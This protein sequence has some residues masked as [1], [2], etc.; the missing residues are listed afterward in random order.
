MPVSG[1]INTTM[2]TKEEILAV[3]Q[4]KRV[5][6]DAGS[7]FVIVD[8]KLNVL[9]VNHDKVT[10]DIKQQPGDLLKCNNA[11]HAHEGCGTHENCDYCKLRNMVEQSIREHKKM[12]T[13]AQLLIEGNKEYDVHAVSTP[14]TLHGEE[15]SIV[16]LRD[17]TD[18]TREVM[19]ERIFFHDLLNL[20]GALNGI[21][22]CIEEGNYEETIQVVKD[23][24]NQL[25]EE[26]YSQRDLIYAQNG[27]LKPHL[28]RFRAN[29]VLDY[30]SQVLCPVAKQKH[31]VEICVE[32]SLS[33]EVLES[34]KM[35]I[36][37]MMHNLVK[38][39]C[40]ASH[41]G[42]VV[43]VRAVV[44][45]DRVVFSVHND[46]LIPEEVKHNM[47][48]FG[49]STKGAG[50]G[51]GTYGTKLITENFLNGKLT[52]QSEEGIGTDFY[53][54]LPVFHEETISE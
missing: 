16:V 8:D 51:L 53:L 19:M 37:R 29:S 4:R 36:N 42:E 23:I 27:I 31:E 21:L 26:V 33:G 22:H 45:S 47:F 28:T 34:D 13:D 44:K 1:L 32:S 52:F 46:S 30:V 5:L 43:R 20:S 14:F 50:H 6:D 18:R 38:N 35:L 25:M 10:G 24:S 3:I 40:E 2:L 12:N 49:N 7:C 54:S 17:I 48:L 41:P 9:Y 15:Y 11:I 39:A